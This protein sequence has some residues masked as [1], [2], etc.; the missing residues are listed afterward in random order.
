MPE[1]IS[2]KRKRRREGKR[3]M[4]EWCDRWVGVKG[5]RIKG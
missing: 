1:R 3:R 5:G 2:E 4:D